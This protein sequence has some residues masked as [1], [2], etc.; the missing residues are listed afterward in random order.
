MSLIINE[1]LPAHGQLKLEGLQLDQLCEVGSSGMAPLSMGLLNL[2][3]NKI[4]T[5]TQ[6]ARL[7][8]ANPFPI[9]LE[10][11]RLDNYRTKTTSEGHMNRFYRPFS[12][13]ED[14]YFDGLIITGAPVEHLAFEEVVYWNELC[15]VL[16][17]ATDHVHS[18]LG[19][20]WGA[21][22]M[23]YHQHGLPTHKLAK[24]AFGCFPHHRDLPASKYLRGLSEDLIVPISRWTEIR[25]EDVDQIPGL[26]TLLTGVEGGPGV[27]EDTIHR[28]LLVFNHFE[29][30][31]VTLRDE[32]QRDLSTGVPIDIPRNYFPNND[33]SL[34]PFNRWRGNAHLFFWNW[35]GEII[36][37]RTKSTES[38]K[39]YRPYA[40]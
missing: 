34:Q 21:M 13:V 12:E 25:Q 6:I 20:C 3:P 24:K 11:L 7:L 36:R 30:D 19:I 4:T 23:G 8:G 9:K 22:A 39:I 26:Q 35:I 2:M 18:T 15:R 16:D 27:I 28:N 29:Y 17:W 37:E 31:S 40:A 10:L 38:R 33:P 5:E 14:E 1:E 32:Y